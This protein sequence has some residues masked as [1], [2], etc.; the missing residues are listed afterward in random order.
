MHTE[1]ANIQDD[2]SAALESKPAALASYGRLSPS[3][4]REHLQWIDE[5]K[6]AGTRRRRIEKTFRMLHA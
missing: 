2:L 4:R 1:G 3:H 5:A 6:R